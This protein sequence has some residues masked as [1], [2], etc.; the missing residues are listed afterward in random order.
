MEPHAA[1]SMAGERMRKRLLELARAEETAVDCATLWLEAMP[2]AMRANLAHQLI[3]KLDFRG[4]AH[5]LGW[6]GGRVVATVNLEHDWWA[7]LALIARDE[8][9]RD[10]GSAGLEPDF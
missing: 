7:L 4:P 8:A 2:H 1:Y 3:D 9:Y 5:A 6:L 10:S